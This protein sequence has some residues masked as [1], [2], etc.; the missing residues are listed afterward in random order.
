MAAAG[1]AATVDDG[2][3]VVNLSS[4]SDVTDSDDEDWVDEGDDDDIDS[5]QDQ[6]ETIKELK[7]KLKVLHQKNKRR[8]KRI[9]KLKN[10][11]AT[12][13]QMKK[14]LRRN[15]SQAYTNWILS[16]RGTLR[17]RRKKRLQLAQ[18]WSH[19]GM[20]YIQRS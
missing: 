12:K 14:F 9:E 18:K 20:N 6:R 16:D 7:K 13:D 4:D 5:D 8:D 3:V 1:A 10:R 11:P 15:F 19:Q 17:R 2:D